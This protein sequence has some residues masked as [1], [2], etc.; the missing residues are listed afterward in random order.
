MKNSGLFSGLEDSEIDAMVKCLGMRRV[1]YGKGE[2]ISRRGE[3]ISSLM[4]VLNGKVRLVKEDFWGNH[5][6]LSEHGQGSIVGTQYACANG[7]R[8]DVSILAQELSEVL[9]LDVGKVSKTCPSSCEFH[10]RVV[11]NLLQMLAK[12]SLDLG[13]RLDRMSQ[14]STRDKIR[15]FLSDNARMAGSNEFFITMN[16]QQMADHLGVDRSAMSTELGKMKKEGIIDFD[17]NHFILL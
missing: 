3:C 11:M 5:T 16:R 17:K 8:L 9:L 10:S 15:A 12:D 6:I 1:N 7:E 13:N 14:R 4:V 2:F